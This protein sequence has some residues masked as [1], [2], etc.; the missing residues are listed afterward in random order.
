MVLIWAMFA[1]LREAKRMAMK[2]I[3][4]GTGPI[5]MEY[6]K[7]LKALSID[8]VACGRN[9]E[10]SVKFSRDTGLETIAGGIENFLRSHV[11]PE[12]AIVAVSE[13]QLG[14]VTKGLVEAGAKRI[15]VEKPGARNAMEIYELVK[16][17]KEKGCDI[18]VGYNRRF[19]ASVL[20]AHEMIKEDGGVTSFN[21]E[22]TEW[23]HRIEPLV[24]EPGV[25]ELWFLHNS[26]HIIDLAFH[27]CGFPSQLNAISEGKLSW[28]PKARFVG[29]GI[30]ERGA[31]FSY[32]AD[33]EAP[34]RWS[35]EILTRRRRLIFRP[36]EDLLV[37]AIGGIAIESVKL[38]NMLDVQFKPGYY[39]QVE[40]FFSEPNKLLALDEQLKNLI[41]YNQIL[42]VI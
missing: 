22:F 33:W 41:V 37:Q 5:G 17:A 38:D 28:H 1:Q 30:S 7:V 8:V 10:R 36:V 18:R 4:V 15:L 35:L 13:A 23:A 29:S 19:Y 40:A 12:V 27:L 11:C 2:V 32:F 14:V 25:K 26:T 20:R 34:G 31:V 3:L 21:F 9:E 39:R 42:G 24:K 16:L 6:A